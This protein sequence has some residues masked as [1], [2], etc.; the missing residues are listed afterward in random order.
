MHHVRSI[1]L[2]GFVC[3][4]ASCGSET[5]KA[6]PIGE[7][8]AGPAALPL[9]TDLTS[10]SETVATLKHGERLEVLQ[11]RRRF[12]KV[13]NMGGTEGWVDGRNLL[14]S[15]QMAGIQQTRS[16]A[17]AM[18][19]QG[20]AMVYD[21]LNVHTEPNRQSPSPF[22]IPPGGSAEVLAR[23]LT[24]R[25]PYHSALAGIVPPPPPRSRKT[26]SKNRKTG[27]SSSAEEQKPEVP[28]PP[29]PPGPKLPGDWR[30]LSRSELP[31]DGK[32]S[33]KMDDWTLV[34]M[35]DK[36]AGW[37]LTR[38]LV[39]A[40]PDEVAHY[41]EGK[42]I[43]SYFPLGEVVDEDKKKNHWLWT[44][45]SHSLEDYDFDSFR[46]FI[47]NVRR[48][49]YETAYIEREVKGY[50]PVQLKTVQVT[51]GRKT[52]D[53]PGFTLIT[54]NDEG[55]CF[56]RT[57]VFQGYRVRMVRKDAVEKPVS[58]LNEFTAPASSP[59]PPPPPSASLWSRIKSLVTR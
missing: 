40:I 39:M 11:V 17:A 45:L 22:Q 12:F 1:F 37:V 29:M 15:Q 34:R 8:F 14:S 26:K 58:P 49:R 44:T 52:F 54:E 30:E 53:Q 10:R 6:R 13:R 27:K 20:K 2:A 21:A 7:A 35:P 46:V 19:S 5:P 50:Y 57:F 41:A 18:P 48:H 16:K 25:V 43:T 31:E 59:P 9:R 4:L 28:P 38:M 3:L 51:E 55:Q 42:R 24:P 56:R 33:V 23:L 36:K 47:Y 32:P